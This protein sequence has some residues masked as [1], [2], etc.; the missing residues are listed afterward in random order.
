MEQQQPF[1]SE[2]C[3]EDSGWKVCFTNHN[4]GSRFKFSCGLDMVILSETGLK[5][6]KP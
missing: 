2:C 4:P 1:R 3:V 5:R 6:E